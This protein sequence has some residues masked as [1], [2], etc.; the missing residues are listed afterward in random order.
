MRN[1]VGLL[2]RELAPFHPAEILWRYRKAQRDRRFDRAHHVETAGILTPRAF[3]VARS[4]RLNSVRYLSCEPEEFE[5][6]LS[7][8]PIRHQDFT[9]V[10]LGSGK[11]KA[12]FLAAAYP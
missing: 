9:F 8:L 1:L 12:L 10:D 5:R 4:E 6:C 2:R 11:G 7:A 3:G